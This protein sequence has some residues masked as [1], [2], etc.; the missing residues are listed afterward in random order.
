MSKAAPSST[1]GR[2]ALPTIAASPWAAVAPL[3]S[4]PLSGLIAAAAGTFPA[5][6]PRAY[7]MQLQGDCLAPDVVHGSVAIMSPAAPLTRGGFVALHF[8][9]GRVPQIK[10]L[11]S[12]PPSPVLAALGTLGST[13][14]G[15]VLVES[16]NPPRLLS[17]RSAELLAVHAVAEIVRPEHV[18]VRRTATL[19][20]GAAGAA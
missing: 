17:Y 15:L 2:T 20:S 4:T 16:L 9:D 10:R 12:L 3:A 13:V 14:S 19:S 18:A 8:R 1:T 5:R 7:A 6:D 11:A